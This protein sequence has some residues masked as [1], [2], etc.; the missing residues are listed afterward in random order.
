MRFGVLVVFKT[1]SFH[2]SKAD[3]RVGSAFDVNAV[4]KANS[5]L[6]VRNAEP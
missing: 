2:A 1:K 4:D 5:G 3:Y 6:R